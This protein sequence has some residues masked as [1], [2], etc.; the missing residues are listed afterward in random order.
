MTAHKLNKNVKKAIFAAIGTAFLIGGVSLIFIW[1][2]YVAILFKG[3]IGML[4]AVTGLF[5][6]FVI[7]E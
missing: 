5:I 3:I 7:R 1:W 6:L 4:L 2:D